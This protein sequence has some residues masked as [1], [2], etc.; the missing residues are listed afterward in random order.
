M[1]KNELS[2]FFGFLD[3]IH[4]HETIDFLLLDS[5]HDAIRYENPGH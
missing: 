2:L 3:G 4:R 1:R 5:S